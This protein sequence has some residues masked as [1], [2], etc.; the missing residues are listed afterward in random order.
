MPVSDTDR[1]ALRLPKP[2]GEKVTLTVQLAPEAIP[3]PQ[4]FI[5]AKSA[6]FWPVREMLEIDN[7]ACPVLVSSTAWA[8]L[9]VPNA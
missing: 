3:F 7:G 9:V 1:V 2:A 4:E 5:C 6:E 8:E